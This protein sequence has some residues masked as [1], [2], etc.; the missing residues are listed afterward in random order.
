MLKKIRNGAVGIAISLIFAACGGSN[1]APSPS[2]SSGGSQPSSPSGGGTSTS[3]GGSSTPPVEA[4]LTQYVNPLI[5]T[6]PGTSPT[7]TAHGAGGNTLPAAGLPSGMV[8]WGPDTNTTPASSSTAEPGSPPGYY[9]D[10]NS[11]AGFSLTHMSGTGGQGNNGEI[12]FVAT[13]T[14]ANLTPTFS[15]ANEMAKPGYYAV[16]LDN[17][18]KVELTATLR[19]GFGRFTFP[20]NGPEFIRIDTTHTNTLTATTG[21]VTQVSSTALSGYT[22][23]GNFEGAASRVPVYFYAEFNQPI[24]STSTVSS[25][26][27][28][29][30]FAP[31]APVLVKV[32]VSYVS[33]ANA[34]LNLDTENAGWDFD[35]VKNAADT[36]WNQR[37]HS[38]VVTPGSTTSMTNFYTALYHALWAPSIFSDVN[39]QYLGFDGTPHTVVSGQNAQYSGFSN[40]DVYRSQMPLRAML[41]PT[42]TGDMVQSLLNDADQC[43]AIPRWVNDNYDSG[44]MVGDGGTNIVATAYAF[45]S[46]NFDTTGALNHIMAQLN[47][48]NLAVCKNASGTTIGVNGG[49]STYLKFGYITSG[50]TAIA[51]SSLEYNQ[52]DFAASQFA[53]ALGNAWMAKQA[54]GRSAGWQYSINTASTPPLLEARSTNGAYAN[55]TQTSTDNYDQGSAEQYT[56]MVPWNLTGLVNLLG[57]N[58]TVQTRLD[59]LRT[60]LNAGNGAANLYIGNEPSFAIPWVYNWAGAPSKTADLI[61]D[62]VTTQFAATP[63]GLPG[64]DD[65]GAMSSWYIWAMIGMYPEVPGVAGFALHSPQVS[66]ATITLE[67]GKTITISAAGAPNS[68][69]VQSLQ[70]NGKAVNTPWLSFSDV[71]N[72]GS[73]VYGMGASASSWGTDASDLPPSFG[74]PEYASIADAYNNQG[75]S[76]NGSIANTGLGAAFD[77]SLNS[78]SSTALAGVIGASGTV[79]TLGAT[80]SLPVNLTKNQQALDNVVVAG[81]TIDMP[82]GSTG[83]SLVFLGA[84]GNGPSTGTV[85]VNYTDGSSTSASLTLDDG[86]L[87]GGGGTLTNTVVAMMPYRNTPTGSQDNTKSYLFSQAVAINPGKTV[88]S[89]TLPVNVSAGKM[90]IFGI[91]VAA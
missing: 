10:L 71:A 3:G 39:G 8:Q 12:P 91:A 63:G 9:Y 53:A 80:F 62:I 59:S 78:Y 38:I 22:V 18:V 28:T 87:N 89:V 25:G 70:V 43:G 5:G 20:A 55:E 58:S 16:A 82:A 72:G 19:T 90:H 47:T 48:N 41:Y 14:L 42:E 30:S 13:T 2:S 6:A 24:L 83:S 36:A 84:S 74:L 17:S 46:H 44:T 51:S 68:N 49:R 4:S 54:L 75:F 34:K 76:L 79:T 85:V 11:I 61:K 52:T 50:E 33:M 60:A 69:Y 7:P 31:G 35:A 45:G 1:S 77:G 29:L 15:H 26:V 32:G 81:Q 37:L 65:M 27:A 66:A 73:L 88:K 64:N 56:W 67:N 86:T 40:W 57:G 23:G 21:A